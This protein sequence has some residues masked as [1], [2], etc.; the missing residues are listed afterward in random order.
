MGVIAYERIRSSYYHTNP[1]PHRR[2]CYSQPGVV[3]SAEEA[4]GNAE[5]VVKGISG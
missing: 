4:S 2:L 3:R 1:A 5:A